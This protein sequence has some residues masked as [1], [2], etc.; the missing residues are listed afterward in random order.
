MGKAKRIFITAASVLGAAA[1]A[2][3]IIFSPTFRLKSKGMCSIPGEQVTVFYGENAKAA[4]DVYAYAEAQTADIRRKLNTSQEDPTVIYVYDTQKEMQQQKYG[5]IAPLLHLDTFTGCNVRDKVIL[6]SPD[7]PDAA[8]NYDAMKYSVLRRIAAANIYQRNHDANFWLAEGVACYLT[9][10]AAERFSA[11]DL[12]WHEP[13]TLDKINK[14]SRV[15][16]EKEKLSKFAAV[17]VEFLEAEYGWDTV[18]SLL[19]TNDYPN[20][21]GKSQADVYSA[22]ISFMEQYPR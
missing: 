11:D 20:C 15:A 17:Y 6:T 1:L 8:Q 7:A 5:L 12:R 4:K 13:P 18:L 10:T 21:C 3:G 14:I 9:L 16:Y 19:E 22:W 2:A